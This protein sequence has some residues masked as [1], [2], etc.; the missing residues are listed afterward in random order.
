V[1]AA[2]ALGAI[3]SAPA[4]FAQTAKADR[5]LTTISVSITGFS[6]GSPVATSFRI[7]DF[8]IA[9]NTT[10]G[11]GGAGAGKTTFTDVAIL[12]AS[13]SC[14][15]PLFMLATTGHIM[16]EVVLTGSKSDGD[17]FTWT[18]ENVQIIASSLVGSN[19]STGGQETLDL[20]YTAIT[21]ADA[22]G[23]TTGR[24]VRPA[25][26]VPFSPFARL[27]QSGE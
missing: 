26:S 18:L 13:D 9:V 24:I 21:I 4:D 3:C 1:Y 15:L 2:L 12:K 23:H 16:K 6:C 17:G 20:S 11:T 25:G 5:D 22:S 10:S 19:P 14:S 27:T 8:A 7:A